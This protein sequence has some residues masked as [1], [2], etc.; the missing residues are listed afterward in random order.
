MTASVPQRRRLAGACMAAMA[1]LVVAMAAA[2][3]AQPTQAHFDARK[4]RVRESADRQEIAQLIADYGIV[5][6]VRSRD[7]K[8]APA[9]GP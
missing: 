9:P 8:P 5:Y 1:M 2:S 4:A 6:M 3:A 7:D